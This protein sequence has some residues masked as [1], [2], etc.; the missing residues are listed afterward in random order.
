MSALTICI[1]KEISLRNFSLELIKDFDLLL[2]LFVTLNV[3]GF[4]FN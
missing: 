1:W 3:I 4:F 2:I